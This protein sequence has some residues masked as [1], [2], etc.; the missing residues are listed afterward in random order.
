MN[1]DLNKNFATR[2]IYKSLDE[3]QSIPE[4]NKQEIKDILELFVEEGYKQGYQK[5]YQKGREDAILEGLMN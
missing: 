5:G 2:L 4:G 1:T 3:N